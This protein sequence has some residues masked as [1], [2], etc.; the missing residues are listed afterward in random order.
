[1]GKAALG[2]LDE[3]GSDKAGLD[4]AAS[5]KAGSTNDDDDNPYDSPIRFKH[6]WVYFDLAAVMISRRSVSLG[7]HFDRGWFRFAGRLCVN[8]SALSPTSDSQKEKRRRAEKA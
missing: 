2:K 8:I 1:L 6:T 5:S 4:K 7:R 3:A